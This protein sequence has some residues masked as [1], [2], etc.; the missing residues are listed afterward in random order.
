MT[1]CQVAIAQVQ[2]AEPKLRIT[3]GVVATNNPNAVFSPAAPPSGTFTPPGGSCPRFSGTINSSNIGSLNLNSNI[4]A[5][6]NDKVTFAVVV[7]NLGSG[8]NGVFDVKIRDIFP[9]GP[10]DLPSCFAPDFSTLCV[11]DG[12]GTPIPF[13]VSPGGFGSIIIEL[14]D[15]SPTTGALGPFHPTNGKNI[16]VITL[17]AQLLSDI[18]SGCCDNRSRVENYSNTEGGPNFVTAGFG[19]PFEDTAQVC[20]G[21]RPFAKCIQTT[22]E[23]HT[24]PQTASQ[25]GTVDAAIGEIVRYRLIT[26]IPEGTTLNFQIQDLLPLGLTYIGNP[27]VIFVA[28]NPVT[29]PPGFWPTSPNQALAQCPGPSFPISALNVAGGPFTPGAGVDPIFFVQSPTNPTPIFNIVNSDND[30]DLEFAIIEFNALVDNI[31]SNQSSTTLPNQFQVRFKDE[32][33]NQF[34]SNSGT[35]QRPRR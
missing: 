5:D 26:V 8:P 2:M 25:G 22:S 33:G 12:A 15:P 4:S 14:T 17:D 29:S 32:A 1:F 7:E 28:N 18:K 23:V 3:K 16:A 27:S 35:G 6:A 19:G 24:I 11:T 9:L 21:P 20:V 10:T 34:T 13:T 30:P 31:A